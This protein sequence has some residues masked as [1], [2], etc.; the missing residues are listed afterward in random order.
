[1]SEEEVISRMVNTVGGV[2]GSD[3]RERYR[4]TYVYIASFLIFS[5]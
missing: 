4:N 5:S 2:S 1:M 3:S